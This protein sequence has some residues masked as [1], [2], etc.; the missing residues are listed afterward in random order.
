MTREEAAEKF[1]AELVDY[2]DHVE[3]AFQALHR[4]CD[5][6]KSPELSAIAYITGYLHEAVCEKDPFEYNQGISDAAKACARARGDT[7]LLV[8]PAGETLH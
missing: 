8:Q 7:A 2:H 6:V 4:V 1:A 3:A 5:L